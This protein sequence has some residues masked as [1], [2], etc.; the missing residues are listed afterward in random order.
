MPW[1]KRALLQPWHRKTSSPGQANHLH[2]CS[3][4]SILPVPLSCSS[5]VGRKGHTLFILTPSSGYC[6][7]TDNRPQITRFVGQLDAF[8]VVTLLVCRFDL[9]AFPMMPLKLLIVAHRDGRLWD[10]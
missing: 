7:R 6:R 10:R 3:A 8:C 2:R 4:T 5:L 9:N 1:L